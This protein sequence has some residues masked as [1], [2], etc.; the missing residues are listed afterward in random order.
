MFK[1]IWDSHSILSEESDI[2]TL[3][4]VRWNRHEEFTPWNCILLTVEEANAHMKL[5]DP[6]TVCQYS[7]FIINKAFF[8]NI[9][10]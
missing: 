10:L 5:D 9:E 1:S 3:T 2:Y 6:E 7:I 8:F 4:F